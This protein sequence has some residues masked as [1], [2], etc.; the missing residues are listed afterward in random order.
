[1]VRIVLTIDFATAENATPL[2]KDWDKVKVIAVNQLIA[3]L[4]CGAHPMELMELAKT[5]PLLALTVEWLLALLDMF[6]LPSPFQEMDL[7]Q[8]VNK[9]ELNLRACPVLEVL[10]LRDSFAMPSILLT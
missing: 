6:A 4:D 9:L 7:H 10:V 3:T 1:M 2:A 8:L 5:P